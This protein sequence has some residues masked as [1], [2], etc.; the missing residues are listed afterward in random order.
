MTEAELENEYERGLSA[1]R[2][3][4]EGALKSAAKFM[5]KA[6]KLSDEVGNHIVKNAALRHEI[7]KLEDVLAWVHKTEQP[8]SEIRAV[9][10]RTIPRRLGREDV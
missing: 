1:G 2:H 4:G 10:E 9:I 3:E 5:R 8:I 7:K 6:A